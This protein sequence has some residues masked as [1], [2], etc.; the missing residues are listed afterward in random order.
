MEDIGELPQ[1]QEYLSYSV[2][3]SS[4]LGE[5]L[6]CNT[7]KGPCCS[8]LPNRFGHWT[9]NNVTVGNRASG[10]DYFRTRDDIQ[11]IHLN[12]RANHSANPPNGTFCC[13]LPDPNDVIQTQCVEIGELLYYSIKNS[14]NY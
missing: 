10:G 7:F 14:I 9:Y 2:Y 12:L 8:S 4:D 6:V 13:A 1:L 3:T 11:Q 5:V